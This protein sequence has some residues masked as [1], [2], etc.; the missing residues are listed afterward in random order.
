MDSE[1]A[2]VPARALGEDLAISETECKHNAMARY[3]TRIARRCH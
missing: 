2:G 1:W 3:R